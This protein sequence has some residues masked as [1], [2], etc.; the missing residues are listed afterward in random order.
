MAGQ[1][2]TA[3]SVRSPAAAPLNANEILLPARL[4]TIRARFDAGGRDKRLVFLIGENHVSA[5]VQQAVTELLG[6][7]ASVYD[8]QLVCAEGFSGTVPPVAKGMPL[9]SLRDTATALLAARQIRAVEG[10]ALSYP[11]LRVVGVEDMD[12]YRAHKVKLEADQ[13][14][15]A[16]RPKRKEWSDDLKRYLAGLS[17]SQEQLRQLAA[18]GARAKQT[19]DADAPLRA[20]LEMVGPKSQKGVE[21]TALLERRDAQ[22][23]ADRQRLLHQPDP[24][25]DRRN[26]AMVENALAAVSNDSSLALVVGSL[27]VPGL[28]KELRRKGVPFASILPAG[29]GNDL[30]GPSDSSDGCVY[31]RLVDGWQTDLEKRLSRLAPPLST[32]RPAFRDKVA[33][34]SALANADLMLSQGVPEGEVLRLTSLPSGA[35]IVRAFAIPGGHGME[36]ER[37][38]ESFFVYFGATAGAVAAGANAELLEGGIAG[39]RHFASYGGGR[40]PPIPPTGPPGPVDPGDFGRRIQRA[41]VV[42]DQASHD[43]VAVTFLVIGGE[44]VRLVD[45]RR[46]TPLGIQIAAAAAAVRAFK[47]A[48]S[49]PDKLYAAQQL[50]RS[51]LAD[52]DLQLPAGKSR[53]QLMSADDFLGNLSLPYIAKLARDP[54]STRFAELAETYVTP[55][56]QARKNLEPLSRAPARA[57]AAGTVM[58][59][60]DDLKATAAG[61]Q[62]LQSIAASGVRVNELTKHGDVLFLVGAQAAHW[63]VTLPSGAPVTGSDGRLLQAIRAASSVVTL[64][65]QLPDGVAA[66]AREHRHQALPGDQALELARKVAQLLARQPGEAS[67]DRVLREATSAEAERARDELKRRAALESIEGAVGAAMDV[68]S[69]ATIAL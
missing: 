49:G 43:A 8:L 27:H 11:A 62:A 40:Q 57:T 31:Q 65:V 30:I 41:V 60:T 23:A 48:R 22:Q 52:V 47:E 20:L 54:G 28:E 29:I 15:A 66:A 34:L 38:G 2:A 18:A 68:H 33:V 61:Q 12:A 4:G 1:T 53:L 67:V 10:A 16:E 21:L 35:R 37:D 56:D 55:W 26:Q 5:P 58:W 24:L 14:G 3:H 59:I 9:R 51:L 64:N 13:R 36:I 42:R 7:L 45:G 46:P 63:K 25:L 19:C 39:G 6:Y 44:V 32:A 50:A 69:T 17:L